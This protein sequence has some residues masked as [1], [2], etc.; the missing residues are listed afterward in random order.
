MT[1]VISCCRLTKLNCVIS[2]DSGGAC[3]GD[4]GGDSPCNCGSFNSCRN[5]LGVLVMVRVVVMVVV[6]VV[7]VIVVVVVVMVVV[8]VVVVVLVVV[9]NVVEYWWW[10]SGCGCGGDSLF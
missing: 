6:V 7:L 5:A 8:V 10:N 9:L 2:V 3:S 4:A 1:V